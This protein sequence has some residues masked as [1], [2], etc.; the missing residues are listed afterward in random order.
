MTAYGGGRDPIPAIE[1]PTAIFV[2]N[3]LWDQD[4]D[5]TKVY[6]YTKGH[7]RIGE[8]AR[9]KAVYALGVAHGVVLGAYRI[10]RWFE[11]PNPHEERRWGFE[12]THTPELDRVLHKSVERLKRPQGAA[13]PVWHFPD[14][15]PS[16]H[17]TD[18]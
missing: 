1:S 7:W 15:V 13:N 3:R 8:H 11:S 5:I 4:P 17:G 10:D 2:I 14:E 6:G 18:K 12:G 16:E 9:D